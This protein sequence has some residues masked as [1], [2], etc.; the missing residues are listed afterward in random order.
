M[1]M[2]LSSFIH[3]NIWANQQ[4]I[5]LCWPST[6]SDTCFSFPISIKSRSFFVHRTRNRRFSFVVLASR[7]DG[8]LLQFVKD[9]H[10]EKLHQDFHNPTPAAPEA[11]VHAVSVAGRLCSL[12]ERL[13][14]FFSRLTLI[15]KVNWMEFTFLRRC[16]VRRSILLLAMAINF[17]K[18][19]RNL[20][21]LPSLC[22][23]T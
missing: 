16:R 5:C 15:Q 13:L 22:S 1:Q 20:L 6:V 11:A 12:V 23:F 9:L 10:S 8:K 21:R 14:L 7:K 3:Y 2:E 19:V 18:V 4:R 17:S